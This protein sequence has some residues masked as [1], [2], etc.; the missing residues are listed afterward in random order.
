MLLGSPDPAKPLSLFSFFS[1]ASAKRFCSALSTASAS[2]RCCS[3]LATASAC[4]GYVL[5]GVSSLVL[6]VLC[7]LDPKKSRPPKI[8]DDDIKALKT[9]FLMFAL[10]IIYS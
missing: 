4:K 3:A 7:C 10:C 8:V 1:A 6:R 9:T 2:L 5:F